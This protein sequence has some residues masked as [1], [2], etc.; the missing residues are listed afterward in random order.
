MKKAGKDKN[1]HP[2]Y[3]PTVAGEVLVLKALA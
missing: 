2:D 3:A 1:D